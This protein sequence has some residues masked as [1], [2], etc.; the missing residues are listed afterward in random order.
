LSRG[1]VPA[2]LCGAGGPCAPALAGQGLL[3]DGDLL[4]TACRVCVRCVLLAAVCVP[5]GRGELRATV[6][7]VAGVGLPVAAG[8]TLSQAVPVRVRCS[9]GCRCESGGA[10]GECGTCDGDAA[11]GGDRVALR[12]ASHS[13]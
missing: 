10:C 13:S 2:Q 6:G 3:G 4:L 1:G 7:A 11:D 12:V 8:L 5:G 9:G